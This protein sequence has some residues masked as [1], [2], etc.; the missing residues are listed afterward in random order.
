MPAKWSERPQLAHLSGEATGPRES[1]T[2]RRSGLR[3]QQAAWPGAL[4]LC[5]CDLLQESQGKNWHLVQVPAL[6]KPEERELVP[7]RWL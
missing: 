2:R 4:A 6:C 5:G 3:P 7:T 1:H